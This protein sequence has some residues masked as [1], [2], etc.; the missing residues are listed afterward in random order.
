MVR[1]ECLPLHSLLGI[2]PRSGEMVQKEERLNMPR[3]SGRDVKRMLK[4][5]KSLQE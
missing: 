3:G 4:T 2:T 1:E 5:S